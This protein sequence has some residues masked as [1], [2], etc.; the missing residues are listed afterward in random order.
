[1]ALATQQTAQYFSP[2][3]PVSMDLGFICSQ[4]HLWLN[5]IKYLTS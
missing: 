1:M 3:I 2:E 4:E 5:E